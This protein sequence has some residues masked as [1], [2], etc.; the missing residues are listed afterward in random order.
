MTLDYRAPFLPENIELSEADIAAVKNRKSGRHFF[1]GTVRQNYQAARLAVQPLIRPEQFFDDLERIAAG[2]S[3]EAVF[4]QM[5][6]SMQPTASG[7][8][9]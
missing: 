3:F 8:A 5:D 7:L 9:N 4:L 2:Q 1:S 6:K